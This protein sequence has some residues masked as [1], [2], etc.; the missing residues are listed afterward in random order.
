MVSVNEINLL[1]ISKFCEFQN[2]TIK[3]LRQSFRI[4]VLLTSLT[5]VSYYFWRKIRNYIVN[6][7]EFIAVRGLLLVSLLQFLVVG[8]SSERGSK[9][10]SYF[11]GEIINPITDYVVLKNPAGRYDTIPL[12]KNNRFL[13]KINQA[14]DGIYSFKHS[15]EHQLMFLEKGDSILVRINTIEFDESLVFTGIGARKN[16]FLIDVFLKNEA[17]LNMLKKNRFS[18][19]PEVFKKTQDSIYKLHQ[20]KYQ[21][22]ANN[23]QLSDLAK[24]VVESNFIF[25]Y[26]NRHEIY[27]RNYMNKKDYMNIAEID[28]SFYAYRNQI[29]FNDTDLKRLYAYNWF[30]HHYFTNKAIS[31]YKGEF[32]QYSKDFENARYKLGL[33]DCTVE[34]TIIKNKLLRRSTL[35][36]LLN[37]KSNTESKLMLKRFLTFSTDEK[38]KL[39]MQNLYNALSKLRPN[40]I[41]PE[42]ELI[43]LEGKTIKL[44]SLF[45]TPI[46]A[47]Y[48]WSAKNRS[49]YMRAHQKATHLKTLYP[50]INFIAVNIDDD[51]QTDRW[52][53]TVKR[54]QYDLNEEY[55]FKYPKCSFEELVI[56]YRS[57]VI[58]VDNEG[59]IINSKANLFASSF[60]KELMHYT[61]L[62]SIEN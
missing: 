18:Q 16:N 11:G 43:N 39:K 55:G 4:N 34:N 38:S 8:C 10:D 44:S 62:A 2:K 15:A 1:I 53:Q 13:Y 41:I 57:K 14:E 31:N 48:F 59:K 50:E 25:G 22:L 46:T 49:H 40:S 52:S 6:I 26:Y 3:D 61:R 21:K 5:K 20:K 45:N 51:D 60:E 35:N 23:Y 19:S 9:E 30:L 47:I 7:M 56:H 17:D 37:N 27:I 29:N 24:K 58:L 54:H 42:Q 32:P 28:P 12:D 33:V 36:F